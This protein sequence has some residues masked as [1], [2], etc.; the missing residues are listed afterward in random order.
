MD[1]VGKIFYYF[2]YYCDKYKVNKLMKEIFIGVFIYEW[3]ISLFGFVMR[4]VLIIV[5]SV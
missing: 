2:F 4:W 3:L 1:I 5:S